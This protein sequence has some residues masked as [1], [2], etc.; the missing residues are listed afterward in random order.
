MDLPRWQ[1]SYYSA[2]ESAVLLFGCEATWT[3]M[4]A[5]RPGLHNAGSSAGPKVV[6]FGPTIYDGSDRS[7]LPCWRASRRASRSRH[8]KQTESEEDRRCRSPC[9]HIAPRR[10]WCLLCFSLFALLKVRRRGDVCSVLR[11]RVVMHVQWFL[12]PKVQP[13]K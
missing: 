12:G 3:S 4:T 8:C 13:L 10:C 9:G 6:C 7:L 5:M 1:Y 2:A 11:V